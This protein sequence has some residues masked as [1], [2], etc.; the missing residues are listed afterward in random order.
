MKNQSKKWLTALFLVAITVGFSS[1]AMAVTSGDVSTSITYP[2]A[3]ADVSAGDILTGGVDY[4]VELQ[5]S[6]DSNDTEVDTYLELS[7]EDGNTVTKWVNGTNVDAGETVT[8]D[9]ELN[10]SDLT[11]ENGTDATLDATSTFTDQGDSSTATASDSVAFN[12]Q[13]SSAFG[14]I[15]SGLILIVIVGSLMGSKN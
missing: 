15:M 8:I 3:D 9:G 11:Y 12:L 5:N 4:E 1:S 7:D 10:P 6:M 2:E 13:K 14:V